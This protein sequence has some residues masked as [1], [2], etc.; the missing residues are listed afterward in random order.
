M[1]SVLVPNLT[2]AVSLFM[3]CNQDEITPEKKKKSY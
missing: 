1:D 2:E 3:K